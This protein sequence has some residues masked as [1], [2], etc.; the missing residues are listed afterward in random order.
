MSMKFSVKVF[1]GE[2]YFIARVPEL[3]I[4]TQGKTA[5]E[6]RRNLREAIQT[7][8]EAMA[9]YAIE[10]GQVAIDRGQLVPAS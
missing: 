2:K 5:K 6:A 3:G 9:D 8:L 7:H 10:H 4:T 1:K